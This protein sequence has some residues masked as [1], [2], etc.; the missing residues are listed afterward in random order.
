[1]EG[2]S[3]S[4]T[5]QIEPME[6]DKFQGSNDSETTQIEPMEQDKFQSNNVSAITQIEVME[7]DYDSFTKNQKDLKEAVEKLVEIRSK[8]KSATDM[9]IKTQTE[10][11][12]ERKAK[13][14]SI[15]NI[16]KQVLQELF[17]DVSKYTADHGYNVADWIYENCLGMCRKSDGTFD[18]K[19]WKVNTLGRRLSDT[20]FSEEFKGVGEEIHDIITNALKTMNAR[21]KATS[22]TQVTFGESLEEQ[23]GQSFEENSRKHL[24]SMIVDE[25]WKLETLIEAAL[26]C[27]MYET[28]ETS[29][30][31]SIEENLELASEDKETKEVYLC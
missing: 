17:P 11:I 27:T 14:K 29:K 7:Q 31:N 6:Q 28:Q 12:L 3:N 19:Y 21:A 10:F 9:Y 15:T 1:M 8:I 16:V 22:T 25:S 4:E 20:S 24:G 2:S 5:T 18:S 30:L 13:R 26:D 23:F